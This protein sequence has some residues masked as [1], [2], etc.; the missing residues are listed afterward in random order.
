M[1]GKP[2]VSSLIVGARRL[3]QLAENIAAASI[4]LRGEEVQ[5]IDRVSEMELLYPY[6]HQARVAAD[7]M[8]PADRS[9]VGRYI[10]ARAATS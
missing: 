1:A 8:S 9:L 7:R 10:L 3:D 5:A 6:W 4:A 2:A